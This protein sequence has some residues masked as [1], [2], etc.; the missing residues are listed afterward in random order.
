MTAFF[1]YFKIIMVIEMNKQEIDPI[2]TGKNLKKY[3]E[4]K[5][6]SVKEIQN[7]LCLEC[8]QP[9][10]R[11]FKGKT[12]PSIHHLYSLSILFNVTMNDLIKVKNQRK[13]IGYFVYNIKENK[14]I[15]TKQEIF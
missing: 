14:L 8:P 6:Y 7:Y 4:Q 15:L 5:G 11:W 12:L 2:L 9:I 10:Y 3:V 1:F 13:E